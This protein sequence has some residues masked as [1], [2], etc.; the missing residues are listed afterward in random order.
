MVI[1]AQ[2]QSWCPMC[3]AMG[4]WGFGMMLFWLI[5]AIALLWFFIR[6]LQ[7]RDG[8]GDRS[9]HDPARDALRERYARGEIDRDTYLRMLDDLD[10]NPR[11]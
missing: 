1:F 3:G 9:A 4:A 8:S 5:V 6:A 7:Q 11:R 2:V 10:H